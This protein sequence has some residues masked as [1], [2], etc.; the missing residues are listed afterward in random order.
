[1]RVLAF[2]LA[3][4]IMLLL[5]LALKAEV[6]FRYQRIEE[7]DHIDIQLFAF[8]GLWHTQYQIPTLQLEWEKGPQLEIEQT[9]KGKGGKREATTKTRFRYL[10]RGLLSHIWK[11]VP[12][13][14]SYLGRVKSQFYRG[15][16]C[17]GINWQIEIGY[18]DAAQT[19][20]AAGAFW[21][22]LGFALAHLYQQVTVEVP[23]PALVV[24]PQF[25]KEG[26]RCDIQ[27]IFHLRMGHIIFA[28]INLLRAF[29]RGIRG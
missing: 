2:L 21:S 17:K 15:I 18:K 22:M 9:A 11:K 14:L 20:I 3:M 19:A 4:T 7:E 5:S 10:R 13:L 1:M 6:D 26:F 25:K 27:C 12:G 23:C 16:H 8:H 29:K 28:G 24:V